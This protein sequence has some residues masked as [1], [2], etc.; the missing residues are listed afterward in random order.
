MPSSRAASVADANADGR[1][2][3][4]GVSADGRGFVAS[5]RGS[6]NYHWQLIR[7]RAANATGDQRINSFGVGGEME[8]RAGLL[9]QKQLVAGPLA[10]N[11][12]RAPIDN[13]RG[14]QMAKRLGVPLHRLWGLDPARALVV[15]HAVVADHEVPEHPVERLVVEG[16]LRRG[17]A[18]RD[19]VEPREGPSV[20][21]PAGQKSDDRRRLRLFVQRR[22]V[23]EGD[24]HLGR[25]EALHVLQRR[26]HR[27]GG[28][29]GGKRM[30][31]AAGRGCGQRP[32]Q[33][34]RATGGNPW[35]P[36]R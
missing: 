7:P 35:T 22:P 15:L 31:V 14:N 18:E 20:A 11:F 5:A 1:L 2:D 8:I 9:V 12:W 29:G 17:D 10:P 33:G 32:W 16:V 27:H 25:A 34:R 3:L 23:A 24:L 19:V 13:D 30:V 36:V 6:K 4:I 21:G 26:Q 28:V